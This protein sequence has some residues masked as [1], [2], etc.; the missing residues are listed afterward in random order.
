MKSKLKKDWP[1]PK[2]LPIPNFTTR[3]FTEKELRQL[4]EGEFEGDCTW[5]ME[6]GGWTLVVK[7][8][9]Q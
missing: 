8:T 4:K 5:I 6:Q 1:L 9:L 2:P 7:E 3:G